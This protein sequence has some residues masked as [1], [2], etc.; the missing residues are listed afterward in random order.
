MQESKL[1]ATFEEGNYNFGSSVC[2]NGSYAIIGAATI[3]WN[4]YNKGAAY[5]FEK[6][7]DDSWIKIRLQAFDGYDSDYF[8]KS[9]SIAGDYA[10]VGACGVNN[11]QGAA[12]IF[13]RQSDGTWYP[14]QPRLTISDGNYGDNFGNSVSI[15]GSIAIVGAHRDEFSKGRAYIFKRQSDFPIWNQVNKVLEPSNNDYFGYSVGISQLSDYSDQ[16]WAIVG[17]PSQNL[18]DSVYLYKISEPYDE[19]YTI[20]INMFNQG[21]DDTKLTLINKTRNKKFFDC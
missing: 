7:V 17:A 2:I 9:V 19:R 4:K 21:D 15:D 10:I 18:N 1:T 13:E 3:A 6:Q 14:V 20:K 12:Y 11:Y 16:W 8:G 5:I